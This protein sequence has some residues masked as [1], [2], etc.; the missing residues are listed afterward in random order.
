MCVRDVRCGAVAGATWAENRVTR[1]D[2][3]C[4][5]ADEDGYPFP[6]FYHFHRLPTGHFV[7]RTSDTRI[8]VGPI[9]LDDKEFWVTLTGKS[10]ASRSVI[11]MDQTVRLRSL[12][13]TIH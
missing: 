6:L 1:S 4:Q 13:G 11:L 9:L 12:D 8:L 2:H 10:S 3:R 7:G 5:D